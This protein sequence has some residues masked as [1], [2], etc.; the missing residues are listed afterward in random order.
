M[1]DLLEKILLPY[2]LMAVTGGALWWVMRWV[3]IRHATRR[4][5]ALGPEGNR[6]SE[7]LLSR[8][9]PSSPIGVKLGD[10][11]AIRQQYVTRAAFSLAAIGLLAAS[12]GSIGQLLPAMHDVFPGAYPVL[13]YAAA[14]ILPYAAWRALGVVRMRGILRR[15]LVERLES[16]LG[17]PDAVSPALRRAFVNAI[18]RDGQELIRSHNALIDGAGCLLMHAYSLVGFQLCGLNCW[19]YAWSYIGIHPFDLSQY[20][21]SM[22]H[23][24][25]ENEVYYAPCLFY[26]LFGIAIPRLTLR[27]TYGDW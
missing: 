13:V 2:L 22:L 11:N 4:A 8:Q 5:A 14:L 24:N 6:V 21:A 19:Y 23:I 20:V 26:L 3:A 12:A 25:Q 18:K 27:N 1:P 16:D 10:L 7:L 15:L 9:A 17:H